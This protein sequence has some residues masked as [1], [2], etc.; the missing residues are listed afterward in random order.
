M[1]KLPLVLLV[2]FILFT[3]S[4]CAKASINKTEIDRVFNTRVLGIDKQENGKVR[5][6]IATKSTSSSSQDSGG[7]GGAPGGKSEI[8]VSDGETVFEAARLLTTYGN[9]KP[10]YGHTEYIL[11]GE[12]LAR[13]GLLPYL[14]FICRNHE[15]RYN[16]KIYIV[17]GDSAYNL[18]NKLNIGDMFLSDKLSIMEDNAPNMSISSKVTVSEAMYIFD[19]PHISTYLPYIDIIP[20]PITNDTHST[21]LGFNLKLEGYG[22]FKEDKLQDFVSGNRA[23]AI[24]W[25]R[26]KIQS[27]IINVKA[28]D[29]K[30]ISLEIVSAKTDIKPSIDKDSL[31]C[32]IKVNFTSNIAETMSK[33]N[34]FYD[35]ELEIL[36][37]QQEQQIKKEIEEIIAF[38]Q[39]KNLDFFGTLTNFIMAYPRMKNELRQ[40]WEELFPDVKFNVTVD[41]NINRTYLLREPTGTKPAGSK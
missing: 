1:K 24:N 13:D 22:L 28:P 3:F 10:H 29:G 25:I 14:D 19:K 37:N 11:I 36:E 21:S 30:S 8:L 17:K 18:I 33:E 38:A 27:G 6:T 7:G 2:I 15:F 12:E 35:K 32:D 9:K 5:L 39:E 41:S 34:L 23:R 4:G 20:T 31:R 16:A 26:K 40:N